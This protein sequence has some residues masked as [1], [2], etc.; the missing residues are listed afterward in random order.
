MD[1][2]QNE[3]TRVEKRIHEVVPQ[4]EGVALRGRIIMEELHKIKNALKHPSS[5]GNDL[6]GSD[7]ES[8]GSSKFEVIKNELEVYAEKS[9]ALITDLT[10]ILTDIRFARSSTL[11]LEPT[12]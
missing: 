8:E 1:I 3:Q 11:T 6:F 4:L 10:K 12:L 5:A 2:F 7:K 9:S